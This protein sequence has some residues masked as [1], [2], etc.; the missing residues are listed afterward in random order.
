MLTGHVLT[1]EVTCPQVTCLEGTLAD[2]REPLR[3]AQRFEF[4]AAV[5][6]AGA[7]D[8]GARRKCQRRERD[9]VDEGTAGE[10]YVLGEGE[11]GEGGAATEGVISDGLE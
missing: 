1:G 4:G 7:G 3:K 6:R 2:G 9:A 11:Q 8:R 5:E 10:R